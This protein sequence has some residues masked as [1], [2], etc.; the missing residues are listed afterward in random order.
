MTSI[1]DFEPYGF[2]RTIKY[3]GVFDFEG[4][5]K[6]VQKWLR[7]RDW[8]FFE[9]QAKDKPPWLIYKWIARKKVTFY[10]ALQINLEFWLWEPKE[11]EVIKEGTKKKLTDS[12]MKILLN[13]AYITDYDGDFEKSDF[14]KKVEK[15]LNG[16][17]LYHE[18][19]LKYFDYLDYYIYGLMTDIKKFLGME[20]A[21]NAY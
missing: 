19:L 14:L 9:I 6:Y 16:Y 2:H 11:V 8:D 10:A 21:T 18:I 3:R 20:T 12:R 1:T 13:G 4:L 17:V 7:D 15:F 5:Y